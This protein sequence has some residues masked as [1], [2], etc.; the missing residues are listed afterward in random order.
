M[1]AFAAVPAAAANLVA[2][3][4]FEVP[5]F[6]PGCSGSVGCA[7]NFQYLSDGD[8]RI[9][10]W[11]ITRTQA[12]GE[13]PYWFHASRFVV[14]EG[15]F[16]L[17]LT[18]GSRASTNVAVEAA[19]LYHL[20]FVADRDLHPPVSNFA[21][22][23]SLGTSE[24]T[25]EPASATDTGVR[26]DDQ[27]NWLRYDVFLRASGTGD[28]PLSIENLPDGITTFDGGVMI[29]AVELERAASGHTC[30][31]DGDGRVGVTDGVNVLRA[32]ADLSSTCIQSAA[33]NTCDIDGDGRVGVTDGV[34]VLRAAADLSS[35]C[36]AE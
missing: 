36:G 14:F 34:N 4:S 17:A 31:V 24:T 7:S 33:G 18:D 20:S 35:A 9:A 3:G 12:V 6:Q 5:G 19:Q 29:D 11:T 32:A 10:G 15:N 28:L 13:S 8:T 25:V 26:V 23:V 22:S 27:Q 30:D 1:V 21:L 16:A 2:N